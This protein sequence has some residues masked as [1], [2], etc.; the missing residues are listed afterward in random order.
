MGRDTGAWDWNTHSCMYRIT[1]PSQCFMHVNHFFTEKLRKEL[2]KLRTAMKQTS[3]KI[4]IKLY[5][6]VVNEDDIKEWHI[7][8]GRGEEDIDEEEIEALIRK[9][10]AVKL[11][12]TPKEK[13]SL[14]IYGKDRTVRLSCTLSSSLH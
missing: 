1:H 4:V 12:G 11:I 7:K 2:W 8:D 10:R 5:N 6:L 14:F 9:E 3:E 13:S